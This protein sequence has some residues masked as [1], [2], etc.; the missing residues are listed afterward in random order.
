[1]TDLQNRGVNDILINCVDA[2][3]GFS[4]VINTIYPKIAVQL[5][6]MHQIRHS[7]KYVASKHHKTL[8]SDL[9]P[10]YKAV[11]RD[12]EVDALKFQSI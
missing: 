12:A 6:I 8:M 4:E 11:S 3:V 10:V 1:L 7:I 9:K 2:L 5:C